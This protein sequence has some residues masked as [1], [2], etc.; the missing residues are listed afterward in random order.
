[1][2]WEDEGYKSSLKVVAQECQRLCQHLDS[3]VA[4]H[5][6]M[7]KTSKGDPEVFEIDT[8]TGL[9]CRDILGDNNVYVRNRYKADKRRRNINLVTMEDLFPPEYP[10]GVLPE[11]GRVKAQR[12]LDARDKNGPFRTICDLL[13]VKGVG[14][15]TINAIMP[16]I[17]MG[18]GGSS[19]S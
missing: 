10:R 17:T 4:R 3:L 6:G 8:K 11:I 12:I 1:M 5:A 15:G 18:C 2:Q 16:F 19:L 7:K 13:A 9:E 14:S